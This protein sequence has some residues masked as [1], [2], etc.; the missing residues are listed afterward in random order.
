[1]PYQG[2]AEADVAT[3]AGDVDFSFSPIGSALPL[4]R[5]ARLRA[6]AVTSLER[7]PVWPHVETMTEAGFPA[8]AIEPWVG[9]ASARPAG[10]QMMEPL[11]EA[12][13][14]ALDQ[15]GIVAQLLSL[16]AVPD[17]APAAPFAA[18]IAGELKAESALVRRLGP[19]S[20]R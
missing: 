18:Q 1:V 16:G 20:L 5:S 4:V 17:F 7:W 14:K 6:L 8:V 3:A 11:G 19:G 12:L 2:G 15:P 13:R 10:T 9:L